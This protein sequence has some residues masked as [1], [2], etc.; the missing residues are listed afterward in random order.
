MDHS[1]DLGSGFLLFL[2]RAVR[3]VF[4]FLV[5]SLIFWGRRVSAATGVRGIN[6]CLARPRAHARDPVKI[7]VKTTVKPATLG[8]GSLARYGSSFNGFG[9]S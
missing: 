7:T 3:R 4:L 9:G 6:W 1:A 8:G 2:A 5:L